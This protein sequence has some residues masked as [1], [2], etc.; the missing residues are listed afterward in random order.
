MT[1]TSTQPSTEPKVLHEIYVGGAWVPSTND[2]LI[3]VHNPYTEQ[4]IARVPAGSAED[5]DAAVSAARAA[6][7]SWSQTPVAERAAYLNRVADVLT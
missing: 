7:E 3:D 1:A 5:V 4:V 6:F 2:R